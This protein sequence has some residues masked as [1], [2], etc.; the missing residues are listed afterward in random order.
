[1]TRGVEDISK[2]TGNLGNRGVLLCQVLLI[3]KVDRANYDLSVMY[4]HTQVP[5]EGGKGLKI[6]SELFTYNGASH[7]KLP[8]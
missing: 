6:I 5:S 7:S 2:I 1:M 3:R 8:P 4:I